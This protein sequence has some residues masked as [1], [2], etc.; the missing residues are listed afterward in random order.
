MKFLV[1]KLIWRRWNASTAFVL[2]E[3]F[4]DMRINAEQLLNMRCHHFKAHTEFHF[5]Q[6][7][8]VHED[9]FRLN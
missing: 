6:I 5:H 7:F 1:R 8:L 4:A 3:G 9:P 2:I